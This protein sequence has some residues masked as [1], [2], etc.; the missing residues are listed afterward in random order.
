MAKRPFLKLFLFFSIFAASPYAG[1]VSFTSTDGA[2]SIDMPSG[3]TAPAKLPQRGVL[4]LQKGTARIDI[5][6]IA[7]T[8]ETCIEKKV[9]TDLV[10][11]KRK[12]MQIVGNSYTGEEVKRIEFS[13]GEPFFYISFFTP[14]TTLA[15]G[16]F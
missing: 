5:K 1:A 16:I 8:T 9:N 12:K 7:C 15:R 2:F 11:V 6:T 13:T 14:K 10:D 4:S 3:W